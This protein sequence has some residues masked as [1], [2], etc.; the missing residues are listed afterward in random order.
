[1]RPGATCSG[2]NGGPF[3][4]HPAMTASTATTTI[5]RTSGPLDISRQSSAATAGSVK[6]DAVARTG[7][8]AASGKTD[9]R[10]AGGGHPTGRTPRGPARRYT[11]LVARVLHDTLTDRATLHSREDGFS[12][13]ALMKRLMWTLAVAAMLAAPAS[14]AA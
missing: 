14:A 9:S 3:L 8:P 5:R 4:P 6:C 13:G 11:G 7:S 2:G 12:E 10:R 1:M